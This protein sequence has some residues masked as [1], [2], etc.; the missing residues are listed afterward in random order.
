MKQFSIYLSGVGGQG[1]GLLSETLLRAADYAGH[2]VKG[3]DTHGLAQRGGSV[4]SQ[5]RIGSQVH[6]PLVSRHQADLLI[7][8][9]RHEALRSLTEFA[10]EG[11]TLIYYNT[12]WQPL[13]V[14]LGRVAEVSS[15]SLGDLCRQMGVKCIEVFHP[16][17]EDARMQN[18]AL[19]ARIDKEGLVPGVKSDHYRQALKDLMAVS[20]LEK[21]MALYEAYRT[22]A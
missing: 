10:K 15:K 14:R 1:I 22:A 20:M 11:A 3:V 17:L 7:S 12:V 13:D 19:L 18:V 8:L 2:S 5:I 6:T 4:V 9:E 21:N 16:D